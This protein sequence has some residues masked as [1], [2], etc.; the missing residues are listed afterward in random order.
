MENEPEVAP[1]VEIAA[2][3]VASGRRPDMDAAQQALGQARARYA[4]ARRAR[5]LANERQNER[6]AA[7]IA[8]LSEQQGNIALTGSRN[9]EAAEFFLAAARETPK[10]DPEKAGRRFAL[11]SSALLRHGIMFFANDALREVIRITR[12]ET[13]LH[14][15]RVVPPNSDYEQMMGALKTMALVDQADAQSMLSV[16]HARARTA[17]LWW[18]K[19]ARPTPAPSRRWI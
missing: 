8:T 12:E 4:E 7:N 3:A 2:A 10:S 19:P 14:Y 16:P 13:L 11:A 18:P 9:R 5:N 15:D 1:F 17:K 6:A